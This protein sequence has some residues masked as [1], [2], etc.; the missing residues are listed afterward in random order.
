MRVQRFFGLLAVKGTADAAFIYI[1]VYGSTHARPIKTLSGS[2]KAAF[3][4]NVGRM[5]SLKHIVSEG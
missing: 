4:L 1:I 2:P 3:D 5:N